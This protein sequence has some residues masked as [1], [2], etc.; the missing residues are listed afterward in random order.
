MESITKQTTFAFSLTT[1]TVI[2]GYLS[3]FLIIYFLIHMYIPSEY[4][5][6]AF[7]FNFYTFLVLFTNFGLGLTLIRKLSVL[8]TNEISERSE[9]ISE[10]FKWIS[11]FGIIISAGL[12]FSSNFFEV[13]YK[14]SYLNLSLKFISIYLFSSNIILYFEYVFR[15]IW[16][17]NLYFISNITFNFFKLFIVLINLILKFP[18]ISLIGFYAVL[19]LVQ[20]FFLIF[21]I[22]K[23]YGYLSRIFQKNVQIRKELFKFSILVFIP[24]L[25][26]Y[27]YFKFNQF[28]LAF[29]IDPSG[30]A[31]YSLTLTILDAFSL[32]ILAISTTIFPYISKYLDN[33][34]KFKKNIDLIYNFIF[35]YGLLITIP[36]TLFIFAYSDRFILLFFSSEYLLVSNFLKFYILYLN[37][38]IIGIAGA[39]FLYAANR[40]MTVFKLTG[41]N[42]LITLILSSLLIPI[43]YS[44]GAILSIIIPHSIYTIFTITLVKKEFEI[45]FYYRVTTSIFKFILSAIIS[46]IVVMILDIQVFNNIG[47][48]SN[49]QFFFYIVIIYFGTFLLLILLLQAIKTNE[50]KFLYVNIR[51]LFKKNS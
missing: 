38:K 43:Y 4:A 47:G 15:G 25:F 24:G 35:K 10:G 32:P 48:I 2:I 31:F 19:S 14:I 22:Q 1:I 30:I 39:N 18:L 23:K 6:Y 5:Y 17:F 16:K 46:L 20:S 34:D 44:Y 13:I 9:L 27:L 37:I 49:L 8:K 50:I 45:E 21:F 41:L 33:Q 29:Y 7:S 36:L 11:I 40:P 28:L 51:Y 26:T 12:F 42:A 3:N